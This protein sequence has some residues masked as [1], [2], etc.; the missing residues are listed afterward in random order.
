MI[1]KNL[2]KNEKYNIPVDWF[3]NRK[4]GVSAFIRVKNEEEYIKPCILSIAPFFDEIVIAL[5]QSTD[6]TRSIL[7]S[8]KMNK[9]KIYDYPFKL[10]PNGPTHRQCHSASL[11]DNSYY[12]NWTLSKTNFTHACKWDGDMVAL[13]GL[14]NLKETIFKFSTVSIRGLN[15][16]DKEIKHLSRDLPST[17]AEPRF[18]KILPQSYYIQGPI[19][20]IFHKGRGANKNIGKPMFLHFKNVK[21][22]KSASAIW[23]E[24]W[25][26]IPIF[27][28]LINRRQPGALYKG[29]IP[30]VL[31]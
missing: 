24:N 15:I 11:K 28:R 26:N 8:L 21:N 19:C 3:N 10:H 7:E 25:K 2:E 23:P 29:E 12:Y 22:I 16:A 27:K 6:N 4:Q 1:L 5:N 30:G 14:H 9:I 20:E 13:S 18:F 31:K 17:A